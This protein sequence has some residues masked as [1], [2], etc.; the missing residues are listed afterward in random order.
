MQY[1]RAGLLG[2]EAEDLRYGVT[3]VVGAD[4]EHVGAVF[5]V[6]GELLADAEGAVV[7]ATERN[8]AVVTILLRQC[9]GPLH[10]EVEGV[11]VASGV[12]RQRA[13]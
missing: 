4:G 5:L 9:T 12:V 13:E 8:V 7:F 6:C 11:L 3:A 10:G 2:F 1:A